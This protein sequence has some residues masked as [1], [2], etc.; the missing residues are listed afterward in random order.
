MNI[1]G[2]EFAFSAAMAPTDA[3]SQVGTYRPREI[4][5]R[6]AESNAETRIEIEWPANANSSGDATAVRIPVA[7]G[8][9]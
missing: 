3:L 1:Y 9:E 4:S 7:I 6:N 5:V 2:F 8:I